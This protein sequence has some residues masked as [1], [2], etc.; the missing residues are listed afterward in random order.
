MAE[1]LRLEALIRRVGSGDRDAFAELYDLAAPQMLAVTR[2]V[3]RDNALA[4]EA[5]QEALLN[6]WQTASAYQPGRVRPQAWLCTI[7]HRR[8]VDL[9]RSE[10]AR[11]LRE[12]RSGVHFESRIADP[13]GEVIDLTG[14]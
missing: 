13:V 8:A 3:C 7:A 10:S 14:M 11:R 6:V 1:P 5:V 12:E 2:R 9:V 4:E